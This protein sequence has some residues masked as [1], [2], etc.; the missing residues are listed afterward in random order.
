MADPQTLEQLLHQTRDR[1][2]VLRELQAVTLAEIAFLS[3]DPQQKLEQMLGQEEGMAI[4]TVGE[5]SPDD[6]TVRQI[7]SEMDSFRDGIFDLARAALGR[8]MRTREAD[9]PAS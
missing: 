4:N 8:M 7:L 9:P 1:Q 3:S 2:L 5:L 6:D